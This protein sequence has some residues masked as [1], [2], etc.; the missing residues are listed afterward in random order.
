MGRLAS[1]ADLPPDKEMAAFIAKAAVLCSERKPKRPP[2]KPKAALDLPGDLGAALKA[3]A[4][5]QGHWDAFSAGKRR[6]YIEWV[7]EAKREETRV[8]RIETIVAQ[9]AGGKERNWK[10]KS[11]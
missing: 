5:A 9:V 11:C 7:R 3:H 4:A 8:K 6:D 10:Y 1:L 2:T